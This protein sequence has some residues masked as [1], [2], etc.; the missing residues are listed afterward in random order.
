MATTHGVTEHIFRD[1]LRTEIK[2]EADVMSLPW[3]I[4]SVVLYALVLMTHES[5]HFN[6]SV[7]S[8][9]DYDLESNANFAFSDPQHM[10]H[11]NFEDVNSFADFWSW[12]DKGFVPLMLPAEYSPSESSP[13][14]LGEMSPR[15]R[16]YWLWH[17]LRVGPVRL[18]QESAE[19]TDCPNSWIASAL[20]MRCVGP[21]SLDLDLPPTEA[22]VAQ[23]R[24]KE[25]PGKTRW[26]DSLAQSKMLLEE[27]ERDRWLDEKTSYVKLSVLTY[28]PDS[29]LLVLTDI[30]FLF[31]RSGR[32]WKNLSHI[33]MNLKPYVG[34]WSYVWDICF[35]TQVT[36]LFVCELWELSAS[37]FRS[38]KH[39]RR[40]LKSYISIW[41]AIDWIYVAMSFVALVL[42][43]FRCDKLFKVEDAVTS[44]VMQTDCPGP[45]CKAD[46]AKLFSLCE[47]TGTFI[48]RA[49]VFG[50]ILPLMILLRLFKAFS[51][52]PRL[53]LVTETLRMAWT[54]LAHYLVVFCTIF[55]LYAVMGVAFFG[56]KVRNYATLD[57]AIPSVLLGLLG[58]FDFQEME[59]AGRG[60]AFFFYFGFM[61]LVTLV[62]MSMLIALIMDVYC[63]VKAN[64][65]SS[66]TLW[67]GTKNIVV[68]SWQMFRK[69]RVGLRRIL[70]TL[71]ADDDSLV[72]VDT[73]V[74]KSSSHFV[75]GLSEQQAF[76][77]LCDAVTRYAMNAST[78]VSPSDI[79][80]FVDDA[81]MK[82]HD[83]CKQP[84]VCMNT[85][86]TTQNLGSLIEEPI[87]PMDSVAT[88]LANTEVEGPVSAGDFAKTVPVDI[89]L[90]A[91][92]IM[93][94]SK[95][96]VPSWTGCRGM[97]DH[98]IT[99]AQ[100]MY[101]E[102]PHT[103]HL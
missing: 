47:D 64:S 10:G 25:A 12:M 97:L 4:L 53:A 72:R 32:I 34:V 18:M 57:R 42:W 78:D 55:A 7:E 62:M 99:G 56:N 70:D 3:A 85:Q 98:L 50:A 103:E 5:V 24:F 74:D 14:V 1:Y 38:G 28:A 2:S 87:A 13:L 44:V 15:D 6:N 39:P 75:E 66:E 61:F 71:N 79:M 77:L 96:G 48:F 86:T 16:Q 30:H 93:V 94:A 68:R 81:N 102:M 45:H 65:K 90:E 46:F 27:L 22:L 63:E 54:N 37:V 88:S 17:N 60:F 36:W 9:L 19:D 26:F 20:N 100:V 51:A 59:V 83:F 67:V 21:A 31:A 41:N 101:N 92:R 73:L 76:G 33:S 43:I 29:D 8:A 89:M 40:G 82:L 35:Y 58:A 80:E 84:P 52:Q 23:H 49:K 91:A 69:E 11:K 95:A